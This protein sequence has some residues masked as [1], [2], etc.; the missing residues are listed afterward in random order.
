MMQQAYELDPLGNLDFLDDAQ[1]TLP[2]DT[3]L[4]PLPDLELPA[5]PLSPSSDSSL[6]L[7]DDVNFDPLDTKMSVVDMSQESQGRKRRKARA[8]PERELTQD[9]KRQRNKQSAAKYRQKKK[10]YVG[11]LEGQVKDLSQTLQYQ[12]QTISSL[13]TENR[14]LKDQL[15]YL[16]SLVDTLGLGGMLQLDLPK[17]VPTV[18]MF[19]IFTVLLVIYQSPLLPPATGTNGRKIL[20]PNMTGEY[21][22]MTGEYE[23]TGSFSWFSLLAVPPVFSVVVAVFALLLVA[24]MELQASHILAKNR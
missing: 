14:V 16:K 19:S 3:T 13:Q 10:T 18:A 2:A 1:L 8:R 15:S 21:D 7:V 4:G 24:K 12:N 20:S 17:A 11:D 9:E 6:S 22:N 5:D 23:P